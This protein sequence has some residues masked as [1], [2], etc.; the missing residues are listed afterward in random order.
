[1]GNT[2]DC[3]AVLSAAADSRGL[4]FDKDTKRLLSKAQLQVGFAQQ[5][6]SPGKNPACDP[7]A[8]VGYLGA[9]NQLIRVQVSKAGKLLWAY[10][11]ASHLYRVNLDSKDSKVLT[12]TSS[13]VDAFHHPKPGQVV[14]LLRA[15]VKLAN[16]GYMAAPFGDTFI[17]PEP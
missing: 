14:E 17:L 16:G 10:D 9:E 13:P 3:D 5:S 15:T 11:N 12:L 7:A 2:S 6:A 8:Q 1:T 4:K